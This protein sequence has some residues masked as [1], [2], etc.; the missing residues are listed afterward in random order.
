MEST[1]PSVSL[2]LAAQQLSAGLY[3]VTSLVGRLTVVLF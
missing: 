2:G 3:L 1:T